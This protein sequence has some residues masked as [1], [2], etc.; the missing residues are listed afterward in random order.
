MELSNELLSIIIASLSALGTAGILI[1]NYFSS[2]KLDNI[3]SHFQ[4]KKEAPDWELK[5]LK[6]GDEGRNPPFIIPVVE[7]KGEGIAYNVEIEGNPKSLEGDRCVRSKRTDSVEEVYPGNT[8]SLKTP[9][10]KN[11][12]RITVVI[13]SDGEEP[14][15]ENI[16]LEDYEFEDWME[17][18]L[19]RM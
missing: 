14:W 6:I 8:I 13:R 3:Q 12:D 15:T 1:Q 9:V 5:E 10:D 7:N 18:K 4:A 16:D 19:G 17:K 2:Q 11:T